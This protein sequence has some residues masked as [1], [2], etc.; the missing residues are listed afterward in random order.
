MRINLLIVFPAFQYFIFKCYSSIQ[1]WLLKI[2]MKERN[3]ENNPEARN[4]FTKSNLDIRGILLAVRIN[5]YRKS[6][7]RKW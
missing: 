7:S 1:Y 5:R 6:L 2:K 3:N 4:S